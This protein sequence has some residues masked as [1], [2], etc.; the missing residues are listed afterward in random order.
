GSPLCSTGQALKCVSKEHITELTQVSLSMAHTH[1]HTHTHIHKHTHTHTDTHTHTHTTSRP[2]HTHTHTHTH[3]HP[4]THT[5][6][7]MHHFTSPLSLTRKD[8][9]CKNVSFY[10]TPLEAMIASLNHTV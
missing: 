9:K 2:P 3:T 8:K 5:H 6:P 7:H 1:T 10:R 4:N